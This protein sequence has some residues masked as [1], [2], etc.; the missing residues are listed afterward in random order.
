MNGCEAKLHPELFGYSTELPK[1]LGEF[2]RLSGEDP[3][4]GRDLDDQGDD[5]SEA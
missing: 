5:G 2:V 3:A 1:S 4:L